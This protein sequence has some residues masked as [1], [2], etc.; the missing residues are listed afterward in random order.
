MTTRLFYIG[1]GGAFYHVP[2]R[3]LTD[4]DFEERKELWNEYGITEGLLVASGL[5]EKPKTE[6]P[7]TRKAAKDG[8]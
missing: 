5:Y 6:Q 2:T 7:K 3:D 8:E 4:A 1:K